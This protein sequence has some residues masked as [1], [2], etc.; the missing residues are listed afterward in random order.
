MG[1]K[2]LTCVMSL[3]FRIQSHTSVLFCFVLFTLI[4]KLFCSHSVAQV[5]TFISEL[6]WHQCC[7]SLTLVKRQNGCS[8]TN[9]G[10]ASTSTQRFSNAW[11]ARTHREPVG[12]FILTP[13]Y[14]CCSC[15][16]LTHN[17]P[18]PIHPR[19]KRRLDLD[20]FLITTGLKSVLNHACVATFMIYAA[21]VCP[22]PFS[23]PC[24]LYTSL[25]KMALKYK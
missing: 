14:L 16:L 24:L 18:T 20:N 2:I 10:P 25:H 15:G 3:F 6:P 4:R 12:P 9:S 22:T 13:S 11:A 1:G 8:R 17:T 7:Y 5:L 19:F 23:P 21:S